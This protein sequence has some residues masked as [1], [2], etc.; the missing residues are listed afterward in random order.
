MDH[1]PE[2]HFLQMDIL[3]MIFGKESFDGIFEAGVFFHF[4]KGEQD[5]ILVNI[6]AFLKPEGIYLSLYPVGN[7]EG[8]Q[9]MQISDEIYHRYTRFLPLEEWI[10]E[11]MDHGFSKYR[12]LDFSLARFRAILFYK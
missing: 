8:M 10:Q 9:Q 6:F 7:S 11:V 3:D 5:T 1:V 4:T 12:I 2:A